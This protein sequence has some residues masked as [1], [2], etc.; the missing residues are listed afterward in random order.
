MLSLVGGS[1]VAGYPLDNV[2]TDQTFEVFKAGF[3]A[4]IIDIDL[5][6]PRIID[7]FAFL[8][9]N[10]TTWDIL[11]HDGTDYVSATN[12]SGIHIRQI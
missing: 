11:Y 3:S 1:V 12:G 6:S 5:G 4:A 2:L 9:K 7:Y 8:S 10:V